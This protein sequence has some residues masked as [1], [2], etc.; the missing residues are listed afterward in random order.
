MKIKFIG[1]TESVTGSKHL[2]MTEKG[3]QVLLD[4]GL[5]QGMGKAT[6]ALNRDLGIDPSHIDAVILSHGHIDHCGNLPSL[7]KQGFNGRIYCTPATLDVCGILLLDSAHI[8]ESDV[9]F[10]N[11]RRRKRGEPPIKPLYTVH[12]AEICLKQFKAI[13]FDTDFQLNDELSFYFSE[14]GHIIGSAAVNITANEDGKCTRL[15]FTGD[16][17]RYADPLL[18][19]PG[20]FRQADFIICESTYGNRLHEPA[21]DSESKLLQILQRTC[22]ENKGKLVIPAFSLGRTQEILFIFD[23]LM[24]KGLLPDVKIYVDSPLSAKATRVV[25]RH[26]E[27]FNAELQAY[28]RKDA[29]PFG[30]L[31]L[32]YIQDVEASKVLNEMKE[33]CVII[34]ASGMADA[35][36]VKHHIANTVTGW[37]NTILITGYCAPNT[38]GAKLLQGEARVHIFGDYYDVKAEVASILSLSAHADYSEILRFLS[39]QERSLV[40][41]VFL[42]HGEADAKLALKEKLMAEGYPDVSIPLKGESFRLH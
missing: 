29:D 36:R 27:S 17:G 6:D 8:H 11:K 39:C 18:K 14:N 12:D 22:V 2:L 35:G 7:V 33:P 31:N 25:R 21:G 41:R 32:T 37:N 28:I 23:K 26:P 3:R 42:V 10:I 13:P 38:L 16:I 4:C 1:A 40:K 5:Y 19:P 24:N 20:I 15:T 9:A 34:S 30:F